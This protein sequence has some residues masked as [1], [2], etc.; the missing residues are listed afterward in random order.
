M[1]E[2]EKSK[3][4]CLNSLR[5]GRDVGQ[6]RIGDKAR[7]IT[8]FDKKMGM[9]MSSARMVDMP[10]FFCVLCIE[11]P[12]GI[13]KQYLDRGFIILQGCVPSIEQPVVYRLVSEN[14]YLV[15]DPFSVE[16]TIVGEI[17]E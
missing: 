17:G 2:Q 12:Q 9:L 7:L 3:T 16:C 1:G 8:F 14:F 5:L 11:N 6:S 10:P 4:V 15:Q 13:I